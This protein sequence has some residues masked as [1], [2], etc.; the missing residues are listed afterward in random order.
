M[1]KVDTNANITDFEFI[2]IPEAPIP[3]IAKSYIKY[4]FASTNGK[5]QQLV[6]GLRKSISS[7]L[8]FSL[9]L[10]KIDQSIDK[11][12][13]D[14]DKSFEFALRRLPLQKRLKEYNL[15]NE[16]IISLIF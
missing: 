1:F 6:T 10:L 2:E 12:L 16:K 9:S 11:R 15:Q 13:K 14:L 3:E 4:L 8:L 5:W 7:D